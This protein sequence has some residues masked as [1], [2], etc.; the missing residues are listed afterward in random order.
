MLY[1][2]G[3]EQAVAFRVMERAQPRVCW[4]IVKF[5]HIFYRVS[6][7][8]YTQGDEADILIP[9]RYDRLTIFWAFFMKR[10]VPILILVGVLIAIL[11]LAGRPEPVEPAGVPVSL[12]VELDAYLQQAE[13]SF[14]DIVPGAEKVIYWADSSRQRTPRSIVY[15]HGFSASRQETAPLSDSLARRWGANLYYARLTGH[16][17]SD[18]AMGDADVNDWLYDAR[19]ALEIGRRIGERVVLVGTSTGGTL[20]TWLA[21]R[22]DSDDLE[23]L[24]LLSPN[25]W[26]KADG[27]EMLLWPY[28]AFLGRIAEGE[29]VEWEPTNEGHARYWTNRYP[30]EAAVEMM[31]LVNYVNTLDLSTMSVPTLVIYSPEDRVVEPEYVISTFEEIGSPRKLLVAVDE[32]EADNNHV[33]AGDVLSP[34]DTERIA[35]YIQE[36]V[37]GE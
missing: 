33:L 29:Y 17:R 3:I 7:R 9:A 23:A 26:P 15:L 22:A 13:S 6:M 35:A 1:D 30:I 28:G 4:I 24:V 11:L 25:F 34:G 10:T 19:E 8:M 18:D 21:A 32:V 20:A 12:P 2:E 14:D 37:G 36:F 16:G 5:C 31:R 27:I